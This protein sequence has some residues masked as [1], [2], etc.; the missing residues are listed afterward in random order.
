MKTLR[1]NVVSI[2]T[3]ILICGVAVASGQKQ[4]PAAKPLKPMIFAVLGGGSTLEPIAYINKGKLETTVNGSDEKNLIT[5]FSNSYYKAG[6][7]YR[8]IFGGADAGSITVKSSN[9][10][11]ECA[12]NT[13]NVTAT[14]PKTT[15]KGFVMALGTN[16]VV[17]NKTS[18]RRKPTTGEKS[19]VDGLVRD[20]YAA[21]N[22][23]AKT[24][25]YQNL[26]AVDIDGDSKAEFVGSYWI[27]VDKTTRALLFFVA[28]K[29]SNGKYALTYSDFRSVDK[30][31]V[32][33]G[34]IKDVETGIY[35]E[36][37][38]D[39]FD[40]DGDGVAEIFTYQQSFEGAGFTAYKRSGAKWIKAYEFANYHCGY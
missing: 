6:A 34:D 29:G 11:T 22:L 17:K 20:E 31:S 37:L 36:L 12:A 30:A 21:H 40:Y 4:K 33:S 1:F 38:L 23:T 27:E 8:M 10:K 26:T 25:H 3:C 7:V 2:C 24:L 14:S 13:A 18:F 32:M 16:A 28:E 35:N 19:E 39:T 15:L 9:A 5:A